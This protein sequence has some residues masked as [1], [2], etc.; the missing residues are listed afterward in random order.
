MSDKYKDI[1]ND[2]R[3]IC[4]WESWYMPVIPALRIGG[5]RVHSACQK[6]KKRE[7]KIFSSQF[8]P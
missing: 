2:M 1:I 5:S 7:R 4:G 3:S 8:K 6:K